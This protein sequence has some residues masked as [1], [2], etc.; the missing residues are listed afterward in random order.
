V[1]SRQIQRI[2]ARG[3]LVGDE[4]RV[5]QNAAPRI[6]VRLVIIDVQ[7]DRGRGHRIL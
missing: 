6:A 5:Q 7:D 1:E 4:A 2:L 3:R